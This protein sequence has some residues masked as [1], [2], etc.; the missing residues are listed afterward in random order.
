MGKYSDAVSQ[1]RQQAA[2]KQ[3]AY[4]TAI[5]MKAATQRAEAE[6]GLKWLEEVVRPVV[7]AANEDLRDEKL[8]ILWEPSPAAHDP[9][10]SLGI[11][12]MDTP[13]GTPIGSIGFEVLPGGRVNVYLDRGHGHELGTIKDVKSEKI[14]ELVVN[15]LREL[16]SS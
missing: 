10:L 12:K 3:E 13:R 14:D 11:R 7:A 6:A 16:G 2:E 5:K 1:G 4:D 8:T 15:Y 9:S